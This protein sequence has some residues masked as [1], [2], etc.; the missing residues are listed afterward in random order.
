ML[1]RNGHAY[2]EKNEALRNVFGRKQ[3]FMIASF[4]D[5]I[6]VE[7]KTL[8]EIKMEKKEGDNL[9]NFIQQNKDIEMKS[10]K[11]SHNQI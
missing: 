6:P 1:S 7:L 3:I 11:P 10:D 4:N 8:F 2:K 5:W 9:L